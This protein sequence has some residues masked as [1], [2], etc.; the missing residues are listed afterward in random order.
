MKKKCYKST[1]L[2]LARLF[3]HF[4]IKIQPNMS[5]QEKK[6]QRI[7]DFLYVK[8]KPKFLCPPHTK[9]RR[10]KIPEKEWRIDQKTKRR[11]FNG[12]RYGY[13]E[14]PHNANKKAR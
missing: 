4:L 14:R 3:K 9:Q 13:S 6:R 11:L 2:W 1:C 8:T 5:E 12:S 10:K 7:Y